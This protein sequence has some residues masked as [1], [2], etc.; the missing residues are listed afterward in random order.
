MVQI[1]GSDCYGKELNFGTAIPALPE[2]LY[3]VEIVDTKHGVSFNTQNPF[4]DIR[5]KV[6]P[7]HATC[8][9]RFG[10]LSFYMNYSDGKPNP[11]AIQRLTA[12]AKAMGLPAKFDTENFKG[13]RLFVDLGSRQTNSGFSENTLIAALPINAPGPGNAGPYVPKPAP[14]MQAPQNA[15]PAQNAPLPTDAD[16]PDGP[17]D[18]WK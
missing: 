17:A 14:P 13:R 4:I 2:G 15:W 6:A 3:P 11:A 10:K 12:L 5:F 7:S 18:P 1:D 8:A 9:G 16:L